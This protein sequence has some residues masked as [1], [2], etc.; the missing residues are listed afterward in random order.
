MSF[1]TFDVTRIFELKQ[2]FTVAMGTSPQTVDTGT[3]QSDC[4]LAL[5]ASNSDSIVH[6]LDLGC[7]DGGVFYSLGSVTL[8]IGT[9]FGG[10]AAVD[11][12][13]TLI[14]TARLPL[15]IPIN[16]NLAAQL[17]EAVL[18]DNKVTLAGWL[19]NF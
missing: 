15:I 14:P 4:A 8:P 6:H 13:G 17:E 2:R 9:G 16:E 5:F 3:A 7:L 11:V 19:G 10:V 1:G 18:A 12:V